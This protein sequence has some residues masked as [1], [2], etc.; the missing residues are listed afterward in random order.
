MSNPSYERFLRQLK[1]AGQPEISEEEWR[2]AQAHAPRRIAHRVAQLRTE[3]KSDLEIAQLL[4]L[5]IADI[6]G[7]DSD[8]VCQR[9]S[10]GNELRAPDHADLDARNAR[11]AAQRARKFRQS[12]PVEREDRHGGKARGMPQDVDA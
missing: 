2:A 9:D 11:R 5:T 1:A 10:N 6:C 8:D 3:G 7:C 12:R 4:R